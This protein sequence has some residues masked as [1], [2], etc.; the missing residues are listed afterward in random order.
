MLPAM[1]PALATA[2][3]AAELHRCRRRKKRALPDLLLPT[4]LLPS[5][6]LLGKLPLA[7]RLKHS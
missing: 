6:T 3:S 2:T 1:L 4:P 7:A 5:S